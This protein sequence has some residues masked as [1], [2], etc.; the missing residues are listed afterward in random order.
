MYE[1]VI[2][3]NLSTFPSS[4]IW[5]VLPANP[6]LVSTSQ[7]TQGYSPAPSPPAGSGPLLTRLYI[8][9]SLLFSVTKQKLLQT[10]CWHTSTSSGE[11]LSASAKCFWLPNALFTRTFYIH[12]PSSFSSGHKR[13][14]IIIWVGLKHCQNVTA[15]F[16]TPLHR[17]HIHIYI[18][19]YMYIPLY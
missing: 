11:W 6:G 17:C 8:S 16:Y 19:I 13:Q 15:V 3:S 2:N 4:Q 12:L 14:S 5:D 7:Q 18:Y 9:N 10:W 1:P